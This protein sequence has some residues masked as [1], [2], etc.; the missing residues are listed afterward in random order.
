MAEKKGK[1]L[2]CDRCG[3]TVFLEYT[4]TTDHDGGWT[5]VDHYEAPPEGWE[6]YTDFGRLC[7][8][9]NN[10]ARDMMLR[11]FDYDEEKLPIEMRSKGPKEE[12]E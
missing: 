11:F 2:I 4:K 5:T 8:S 3:Q 7:P 6:Y 9:C 12:S 1:L 10:T